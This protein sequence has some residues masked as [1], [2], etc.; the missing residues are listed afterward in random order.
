MLYTLKD[1]MMFFDIKERT[2]RRHLKE[3]KLKGKKIGGIWKFN[4]ANI[5]DYFSDPQLMKQRRTKQLNKVIDYMNGFSERKNNSIYMINKFN[6]SH[7]RMQEIV[8]F[9]SSFNKPFKLDIE[10]LSNAYSFMLESEP[11]II[12]SFIKKMEEEDS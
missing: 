7:Q 9:V 8:R 11:S 10:K 6:M 1:I 12:I 2:V 3:G 4:D 5:S